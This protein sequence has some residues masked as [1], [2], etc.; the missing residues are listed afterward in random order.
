[1][2]RADL[3]LMREWVKAEIAA[4]IADATPGEDG[5]YGTGYAENKEA[6]A[7]FDQLVGQ[8]ATDGGEHA[9]ST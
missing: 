3:R 9:E 4:A 2:D 7:L 1:M 5:C 8:C 6:D